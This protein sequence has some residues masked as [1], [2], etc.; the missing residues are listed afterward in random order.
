MNINFKKIISIFLI[1][2]IMLFMN[3]HIS[4]CIVASSDT[5]Y[6][7][8]D[9][10]NWQG[11]IDY[12][13]V[14]E[15]GID[16]VY[17][18]AS[19]GT[20]FKDPYLEYNYQ[21]A[22]ANGLK[23]GFYHYL[24]AIDIEQ[25][26]RQARYFASTISGKEPDCKLAM[27]FEEF[28][29]GISNEEINQISETFLKTLEELTQKE[30]IIYSNLYHSQRIFNY[31]LAQK[32][33]LWLAYYGN[34]NNLTN[35]KSN[36]D[37]WDG[38]QYTSKGI[39]SGVDG[40]ADKN[41]FTENIFLCEDTKCPNVEGP[42]ETERKTIYYTVKKGDTLWNIAKNYETTLQSIVE[43]NGIQNPNLIYPGQVFKILSSNIDE[44]ETN[45]MG[46]IIYTV[47]RGD[48]L[49]NIARNHGTT[50]QNILEIN[51]IR[52]PNLIY[53]GQKIRIPTPGNEETNN[54]SNSKMVTYIVKRG[55][56]LWKIARYYGVTVRYLANLNGIRNPR[57]IYPGQV[58]IIK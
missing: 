38:V 11:Y 16:I 26:K 36:W 24:T 19:E 33:P 57:L 10:S 13:K 14:K 31:G 18:K 32:Y 47:K 25:A 45:E 52:N 46:H 8:I 48:N 54:E 43:I 53:P 6:D 21:N 27:D 44:I 23:I 40:Y 2:T 37:V 30:V 29:A 4:Y 56:C 28:N 3:V 1:F 7:G 20:T 41:K 39:V 49:W 55:D 35:V 34:Y 5:Q 9:V 17:I 51:I 15:S 42:E 12:K 50:V 58:L 22:K